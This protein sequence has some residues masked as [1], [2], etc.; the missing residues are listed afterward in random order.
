[1]IILAK[2]FVLIQF[3]KSRMAG[4]AAEKID[5]LWTWVGFI[6]LSGY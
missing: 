3:E 4:R 6:P 1:M 2:K 5:K